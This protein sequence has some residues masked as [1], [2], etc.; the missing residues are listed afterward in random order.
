MSL[1]TIPSGPL[2]MIFCYVAAK[3]PKSA[4]NL[5]ETCKKMK[6]IKNDIVTSP[7]FKKVFP[8]FGETI[9]KD[10]ELA[11]EAF[12]KQCIHNPPYGCGKER[13]VKRALEFIE[14]VGTKGE[15]FISPWL[16]LKE[17][18]I[19]ALALDPATVSDRFKQTIVRYLNT[20]NK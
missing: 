17:L 3:N 2:K 1:E 15:K 20:I 10:Y 6:K 7:T 13:S 8:E 18:A 16:K 11:H 14:I 19:K 4:C 9:K 12:V 5:G